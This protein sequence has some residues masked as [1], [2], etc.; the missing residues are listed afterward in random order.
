LAFLSFFFPFFP[1]GASELAF[2]K[3]AATERKLLVGGTSSSSLVDDA[4]SESSSESCCAGIIFGV[5]R[6]VW[7]DRPPAPDEK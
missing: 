2:F 6:G 3:A 4:E 7:L 1:V 5:G